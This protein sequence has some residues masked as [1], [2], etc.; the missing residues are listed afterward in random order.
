M[1]EVMLDLKGL[2]KSFGGLRAVTNLSF[3]VEKGTIMG[4]IGP[5]GYG[6]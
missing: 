3:T 2:T 6:P 5:N 4:L 1:P